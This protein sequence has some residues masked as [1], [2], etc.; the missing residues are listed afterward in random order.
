[1]SGRGYWKRHYPQILW[2]PVFTDI[3]SL[4]WWLNTHTGQWC[5]IQVDNKRNKRDYVVCVSLLHFI[6]LLP[7]S[8][9]NQTIGQMFH[10]SIHC[11][12][13]KLLHFACHCCSLNDTVLHSNTGSENQFHSTPDLCLWLLQGKQRYNVLPKN[14]VANQAETREAKVCY[15]FFCRNE[16][17]QKKFYKCRTLLS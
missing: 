11:Q 13:N 14:L 6:P 15:T 12:G 2:H 4:I 1:M 8:E 5:F 7:V 10:F 3:Q 16:S 9:E 17:I